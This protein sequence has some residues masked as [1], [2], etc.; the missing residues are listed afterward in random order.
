VKAQMQ[1]HGKDTFTISDYRLY[2]MNISVFTNIKNCIVNLPT[3]MVGV[4]FTTFFRHFRS[5]GSKK[6]FSIKID[7]TEILLVGIVYRMAG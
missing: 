5:S 4:N 2:G 6:K 1:L 3:C 7:E